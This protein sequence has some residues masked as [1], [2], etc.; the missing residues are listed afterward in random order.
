MTEN[1]TPRDSTFNAATMASYRDASQHTIS[2]NN[3]GTYH[4][5]LLMTPCYYLW[6]GILVNGRVAT[7]LQEYC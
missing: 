6:K 1:Q 2:K 4:F 7:M 5:G 3:L